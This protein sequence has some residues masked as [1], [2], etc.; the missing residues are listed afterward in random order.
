MARD[1]W[2]RDELIVAFNLYCKIPFTKIN[3]RYKPVIEL[4]E[5]L[6]N[7]TPDAVA[8]KLAN[9]ARLD[10]SLQKRKVAG[11]THGSKGEELI[12]NE[13]HNNW[14]EL[15]FE[16]EKLLAQYVGKSV[17]S[18]SEIQIY[19][20]PTEGKERAAIV[21]IRVNQH[22]FRKTVLAS[23]QNSC[24]ITG[25]QVPELLAASHIVGWSENEN[26]RMLPENGLCMNVLHHKAFDAGLIV[27]SDD[28]NVIV[29][30]KILNKKKD[31]FLTQYF[32]SYHNKPI[33]LPNR[34]RPNIDFIRYHREKN[35]ASFFT[36]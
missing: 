21:K 26:Y 32:A 20:L 4:S 6:K 31:I 13:F 17:E 23:Y 7:R 15:A 36:Y 12:W 29:S 25:L 16:S 11:L 8:Y 30:P 18:V 14:D 27:L 2:S 19:D 34:F 9:F 22:F 33:T 1:N 35:K 5:I 3:A 28:L 24:C 10:P